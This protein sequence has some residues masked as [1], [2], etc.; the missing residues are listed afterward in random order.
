VSSS[1]TVNRKKVTEDSIL[2]TSDQVIV[3]NGKIREK[4]ESPEECKEFLRSYATSPAEAIA[5]VVVTNT[6]TGKRYYKS[7]VKYNINRVEGTDIAKQY[8]HPIPEDF[9]N[10]LIQQGDVMKCA[11]GFTIERIF[12]NIALVVIKV[13]MPEYLL[14][15]E[16]EVSTIMGLPKSLTES[17]IKQVS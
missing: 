3:C 8:F 5:S 16:G 9:M 17:L 4:P 11:G 12:F 1:L 2:I 14:R 6:A 15:C 10:K 13:D 7:Y